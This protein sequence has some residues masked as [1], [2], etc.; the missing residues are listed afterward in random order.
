M[1]GKNDSTPFL[2][3]KVKIGGK[4]TYIQNKEAMCLTERQTDHVYNAIKEGNVINTKTVTCE[5]NQGQ[6]DNPYKRVV[7]NNVYKEPDKSPEMKSWS[8][9]SDNVRYVQHDQ[10]TSQN[11][12]IDTL[13]YRDHKDLYFQL[14]DEKRET[15]DIDFSLYPDITKARYLDI[16]EDIYAE[17]VYASKFDEN[18]DLSTTYLGQTEMTRDTKIKAEERFPIT[19]Q[20]FASGKLLDG[21]ECQ[22]LLDTGGYKV[23]HVKIVLFAMQDS[24]CITQI[25]FKDAKNT[26]GK[27]TICQYIIHDPSDYRYTW[28]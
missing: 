26:S 22:I 14:K 12:D 3:L 11:L 21:T 24:T 15:L 20:G 13:D 18:S 7:L 19:G 28:A 6:D 5:I 9:F 25:L 16:Y 17:I 23:I 1:K 27:W 4:M 10:I 8:I 2:P